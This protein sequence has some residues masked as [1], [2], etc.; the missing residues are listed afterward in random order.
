MLPD[1]F[2]KTAV[3]NAE[4]NNPHEHLLMTL[5]RTLQ[6]LALSSMLAILAACG[7]SGGDKDA[8]PTGGD[9]ANVWFA[10]SE[11]YFPLDKL[12]PNGSFYTGSETDFGPPNPAFKAGDKQNSR[13]AID[14]SATTKDGSELSYAM[15]I[16]GV[17]VTKEAV[18]SLQSNL[19][20]DAQTGLIT[21][22]CQGFPA[23]YDNHTARE[24][25]FMITVSAQVVGGKGKLERNFLLRVR[26][27]R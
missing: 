1:S 8:V 13:W 25:N 10:D 22:F 15:T 12:Q 21:Q 7:G 6:I 17:N 14:T 26:D 19:Q 9:L 2:V 20:I 11:S 24:E 3:D 4:S 16:S 5:S 18:A 23:C 27:S